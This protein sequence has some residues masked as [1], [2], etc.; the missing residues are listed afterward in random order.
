MTIDFASGFYFQREGRRILFGGRVPTLEELAP[1]AIRR[2]PLLESLPIKPGW[3]GY[4]AM[5]PDHNAIVGAA[6]S[7]AGVLYATGFSGH[8]FQQAPVVGDFLAHLA[9]DEAPP[10]DLSPLSLERFVGNGLRPEAHVV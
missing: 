10:F 8:G 5:S 3:W 9:L 7:P 2:L 4:Y 1:D 6:R